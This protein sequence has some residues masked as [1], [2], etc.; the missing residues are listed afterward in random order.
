MAQHSEDF[1][2][3]E[4]ESHMG[5]HLQEAHEGRG[6]PA[7]F[8]SKVMRSH[9]TALER[10]I[11]EAWKIKSHRG[12]TLLNSK[13]EY[14]HGIIPTL[15]TDDALPSLRGSLD[16]CKSKQLAEELE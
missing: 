11:F 7:N 3:Q 4:K 10:Q 8:I 2:S 1:Y 12:G 6:S 13:L 14:N 16:A 9:F 5:I 15:Q